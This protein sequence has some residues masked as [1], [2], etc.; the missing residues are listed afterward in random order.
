MKIR[1][2]KILR[3]ILMLPL[4]VWIGISV[5]SIF[6]GV[7]FLSSSKLYGLEAFEATLIIGIIRYSWGWALLLLTIVIITIF[8]SILKRK[9]GM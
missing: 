6:D 8:I 9:K 5:Y 7:K 3:F 4:V 1:I 2:L